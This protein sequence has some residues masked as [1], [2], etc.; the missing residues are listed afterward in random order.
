MYNTCTCIGREDHKHCNPS[1]IVAKIGRCNENLTSI[2]GI[3]CNSVSV[4]IFFAYIHLTET[5]QLY[6]FKDYTFTSFSSSGEARET[7][8]VTSLPT[9]MRQK[10]MS[11]SGS[12]SCVRMLP[13]MSRNVWIES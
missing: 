11:V 7:I 4:N 6:T 8:V 1:V 5:K 13:R 10:S 12:G 9:T 2:F 3:F